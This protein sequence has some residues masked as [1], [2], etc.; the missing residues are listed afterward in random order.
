MGTEFQASATRGD[1]SDSLYGPSSRSASPPDSA[2]AL[3]AHLKRIGLAIRSRRNALG[4]SQ[5]ELA[6]RARLDRAYLSTVE[7]GR[8]NLTLAALHRLAAALEMSLET[9]MF[10]DGIDPQANA[11]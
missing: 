4:L 9:L 1:I 3:A 7:H 10:G 8:Q 2:D 5:K 6:I 11:D